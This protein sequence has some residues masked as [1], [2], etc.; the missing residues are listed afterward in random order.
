[1]DGVGEGATHMALDSA[2]LQNPSRLE[3]PTIRVYQWNP[4]C[5][6]LG[7]H[8]NLKELD[9]LGCKAEG[10]D[11][12]IRPTGGRAVFH[13]GE[14]TYSV[15]I[16]RTYELASLFPS[17]VF[18][19]I[20]RALVLALRRLGVSAEAVEKSGASSLPKGPY[21]FASSGRYEV[22]VGQKK[23]IG[24]AQ[25]MT[26]YGILHQGSI[27]LDQRHMRIIRFFALPA[28]IKSKRELELQENTITL[29]TCLDKE[30]NL[31]ELKEAIRHGFEEE[32]SVRVEPASPTPEEKHL[33]EILRSR[34]TVNFSERGL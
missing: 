15:M 30:P 17:L 16:P 20:A 26:Q 12:V 7:Y 19:R 2:I 11:V 31:S 32:F 4:P 9:L 21:C 28:E 34:F 33:A 27:L 8:Q 25:R 1:M 14:L 18:L 5:I 10:M 22:E 3:V 23:L 24:S 13:E 6:S 29:K